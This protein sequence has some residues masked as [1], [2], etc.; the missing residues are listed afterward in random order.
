MTKTN[1]FANREER[2]SHAKHW[3]PIMARVYPKEIEKSIKKTIVYG[4]AERIPKEDPHLLKPEI[5]LT[6]EDSVSAIMNHS[7]AHKKLAVLN[8]ASYKNPG[9]MFVNGSSAQEESL[10]HESTLYN[11]LLPFKDSF[12]KKN[13]ELLNRGL[14]TDRALYSPDV[15]FIKDGKFIKADVITCAAPNFS[16]SLKYNRFSYAENIVAL[17]SRIR[18]VLDIAS[19]NKVDTLVLGAW[20]CGVFKQQPQDVARIFLSELSR[21]YGI[22]KVVFA[23]PDVCSEN[24]RSFECC[25]NHFNHSFSGERFCAECRMMK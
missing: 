23:V 22:S 13:N 19:E 10:C 4:K 6:S 8:F 1:Y 3:T 9:G 21:G 18:F 12:Y 7:C 14:Y 24:Y 16:V 25:V 15:A 20:G 2:A 17:T 5:V 11:V